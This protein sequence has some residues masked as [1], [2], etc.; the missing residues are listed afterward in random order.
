M[1]DERGAC[2][3]RTNP[4]H[5]SAAPDA[6]HALKDEL[7]ERLRRTLPDSSEVLSLAQRLLA[8]KQSGAYLSGESGAKPAVRTPLSS[9]SGAEPDGEASSSARSGGG[10]TRGKRAQKKLRETG[11][12]GWVKQHL[13]LG[14]EQTQ[15]YLRVA[16]AFAPAEVVGY[17]L[18]IEGLFQI[19]LADL[20][21]R[22]ALFALAR[23]GQLS[24]GALATGR[25]VGGALLARGGDLDAALVAM[26]AAA[27]RWARRQAREVAPAPRAQVREPLQAL[28][29][30]LDKASAQIEALL[31]AETAPGDASAQARVRAR[32]DALQTQCARL[33]QRLPQAA[34]A[35][36]QREGGSQEEGAL[37]AMAAAQTLT[38]AAEP[39][40][41]TT[42]VPSTARGV[43]TT[44]EIT[45]ALAPEFAPS[46]TATAA[47]AHECEPSP[48]ATTALP[49]DD[50]LALVASKGARFQPVFTWLLALP[51]RRRELLL[52]LQVG[53][54]LGTCAARTVAEVL[55][56]RVPYW[57]DS[58]LPEPAFKRWRDALCHTETRALTALCTLAHADPM[59]LLF[60]LPR[61]LD[62]LD[63]HSATLCEVEDELRALASC[64]GATVAYLRR[65]GE[66]TGTSTTR[67]SENPDPRP[68][69]RPIH[70]RRC[71]RISTVSC[72][73]GGWTI[74]SPPVCAS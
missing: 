10:G 39:A 27:Q 69:H 74:S 5:L 15:K 22:S 44:H 53:V 37:P 56:Q 25:Q 28:E 38:P 45:A 16:E 50:Q 61:L 73:V 70:Q 12:L 17:T 32:L 11:F 47:P 6:L 19:A 21:L 4:L 72:S 30:A 40:V 66:P 48:T 46:P 7:R 8:V 62:R 13:G 65:L 54:L 64:Y 42:P 9:P 31:Q 52:A 29:Q 36:D 2:G 57:D 60:M 68:S 24:S 14:S 20:R 71:R 23:E 33:A 35:G 1:S 55:D 41:S 59:Q 49:P 67:R 26:V 34:N 63:E 51:P 18:G 3:V 58:N 43:N